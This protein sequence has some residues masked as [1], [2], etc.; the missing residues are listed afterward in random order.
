MRCLTL[1]SPLPLCLLGGRDS[2]RGGSV[3]GI[4]PVLGVGGDDAKSGVQSGARGGAGKEAFFLSSSYFEKR[5]SIWC[6][7][8]RLSFAFSS[9]SLP[10]P[11]PD[12]GLG[13]G[14]DLNHDPSPVRVGPKHVCILACYSSCWMFCSLRS[15]LVKPFMSLVE[16]PEQRHGF[17]AIW[18]SYCALFLVRVGMCRRRFCIV[19]SR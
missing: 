3:S 16:K 4:R 17:A 6:G 7:N 10:S 18:F 5:F 2:S 9:S 1:S 11:L 8:P 13:A 12:E 14:P 19:C 15:L